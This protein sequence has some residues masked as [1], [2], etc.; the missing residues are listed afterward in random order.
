MASTFASCRG[1]RSWYV[2]VLLL[3][4]F[5]LKVHTEILCLYRWMV[6]VLPLLSVQSM[7]WPSPW[8][9]GRSSSPLTSDSL[10]ALTARFVEVRE[11]EAAHSDRLGLF[12]NPLNP[13]LCLS[14][15]QR[16]FCPAPIR[17]PSEGCAETTT[18]SPGTSTWSPTDQWSGTWTISE[19]A[20]GSV[21]DRRREWRSP[22]FLRQSTSTGRTTTRAT[23][24]AVTTPSEAGDVDWMLE[25]TKVPEMGIHSWL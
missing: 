14:L 16:S 1:R 5:A 17:T 6:S 25:N 4:R 12:V 10:Y 7:V 11:E 21:T 19:R 8:T 24:A 15:Y 23:A 22:T 9:P 2:D 20:G 13:L 3:F 18:D